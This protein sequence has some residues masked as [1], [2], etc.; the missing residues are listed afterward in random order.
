[1]WP[2]VARTC[3]RYASR[4]K[5]VL[6]R[7]S[8]DE[9]KRNVTKPVH[10]I[11]LN[12]RRYDARTGVM[13]GDS[14]LKRSAPAGT[15]VDGFVRG[16][17]RPATTPNNHA[18]Q[19]VPTSPAHTQAIDIMRGGT[20]HL[21]HH[22]PQHATTLMRQSVSKPAAGLKRRVKVAAPAH[23]ALAAAQHFDIIPKEHAG[24]L[25]EFRLKRA[26]QVPHSNL[27][28]RFGSLDGL[29]PAAAA[30]F[31][32]PVAAVQARPTTHQA[33]PGAHPAIHTEPTGIAHATPKQSSVD[34]FERAMA[35][36]N[37]HQ[38]RSPVRKHPKRSGTLKRI[39]SIAASTLAI[40]LIVSFV[41]YMNATSLQMRL[42]SSRAGISASLPAW[43]PDGFKVGNF[44][45]S[46]GTVT[47]S[48]RD[49]TTSK[50]FNL[51]QTAS[52]WDSS[53][54]LS[55]YVLPNN[56]TYNTVQ[57][58]GTTIYTYGNNNASWVNGGIWYKLTTDGTLSTSQ[59]VRLATSM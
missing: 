54:L 6:T 44:S 24:T 56:D 32:R 58:D 23:S 42:A 17:M 31:H 57:S 30:P 33:E 9:A 53:T 25:D 50:G 12:G 49:N 45:Y 29:T 10:T 46:P 55:D 4:V 35:A 16:P 37:S 38:A 39:G 41:A 43:Q 19:A 1:M 36:A 8:I 51:A 20:H 47:I 34:V 22:K 21:Q 2:P 27:I 3:V 13:L 48:F 15:S 5:I 7:L 28:S 52:S 40:F 14:P 26:S 18:Q 11:E 59:I